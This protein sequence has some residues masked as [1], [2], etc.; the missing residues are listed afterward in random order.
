MPSRARAETSPCRRARRHG[1]AARSAGASRRAASSSAAAAAPRARRPRHAGGP[2]GGDG[3]T[4]VDVGPDRRAQLRLGRRR[5]VDEAVAGHE[6]ADARSAPAARR[7]VPT[8]RASARALPRSSAPLRT[9]SS[10]TSRASSYGHASAARPPRPPARPAAARTVA[11]RPGRCR[12]RRTACGGRARRAPRLGRQPLRQHPRTGGERGRRQL[13]VPSGRLRHDSTAS[14]EVA[15][16]DDERSGRRPRRPPGPA[17]GEHERQGGPRS[18]AARS[19]SH[20]RRPRSALAVVTNSHASA[21]AS[22]CSA[23]ARFA[24][25]TESMS[26]RRAAPASAADAGRTSWSLLGPAGAPL[27]PRQP[28][29]VSGRPRTERASEGVEREHRRAGRSAAARRPG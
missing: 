29:Q 15:L 16:R 9:V 25:T 11:A 2:A 17:R 20:G 26:A 22:S 18:R 13:P 4:G 1:G 8:S 14:R 7:P 28:R 6:A 12:A 19:R 23:S 21:A 27:V 10:P 5:A 24:S 3:A